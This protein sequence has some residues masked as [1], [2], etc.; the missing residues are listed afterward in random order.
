MVK[1][2]SRTLNPKVTMVNSSNAGHAPKERPALVK[3][4][5]APTEVKTPFVASLSQV[6]KVRTASANNTAVTPPI[7]LHHLHHHHLR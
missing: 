5:A 4:G 2:K 3:S 6:P 7:I 1:P